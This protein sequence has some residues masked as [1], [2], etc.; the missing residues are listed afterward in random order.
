MRWAVALSF[1]SCQPDGNKWMGVDIEN[2]GIC[3]TFKVC[4]LWHLPGVL[5]T[6]P[7]LCLSQTYVWEPSLIKQN[8]LAAATEAACVILSGLSSLVADSCLNIFF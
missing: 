4:L 3:D 8:A 7:T 5:C 1:G 6:R 2:E